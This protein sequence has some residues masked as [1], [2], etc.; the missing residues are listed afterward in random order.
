MT[1]TT[2]S[3]VPVKGNYIFKIVSAGMGGVGK[4]TFLLRYMNQRFIEDQQMTIGVQFH[5]KTL[6]HDGANVN[7]ALWDL[8]GQERFRF[9]QGTYMRGAAAALVFFDI[10][11]LITLYKLDEWIKLI[12]DSTMPDIPILLIGT[13]ADIAT[14][15]A[16]D[17]AS[18]E[19]LAMVQEQSLMGYLPTSSKSGQNVEEAIQKIVS[20]LIQRGGH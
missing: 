5:M 4:T 11:V 14:K 9:M 16:L 19:A 2:P 13:K 10:S 15:E 17:Q 8:G 3:P 12:R 18:E 20:I 1:M 7:L 6:Q